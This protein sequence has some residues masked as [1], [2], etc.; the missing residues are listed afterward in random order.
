MAG[1]ELN[2]SPV[3]PKASPVPARPAEDPLTKD[4]WRTLLAIADTIVPS[5][6]AESAGPSKHGLVIDDSAYSLTLSTLQQ[7]L[8]PTDGK[9]DVLAKKFLEERPSENPAFKEILTRFFGLWAP[10]EAKQQITLILNLLN[11]RPGAA[12]LTGYYAPFHT[13]P[14][15]TRQAI[16]QSWST[17]RIPTFRLL[18]KSFGLI[19]KQNWAKTSPTISEVISFPRTPLHGKPAKGFPYEFLQIPP[20]DEPEVIETDVVIVGSGCGGAV[21]ARNL[22]ESGMKVLVVDRGY[23]WAPEHLPMTEAEGMEQLFLNGGA[24]TCKWTFGSADRRCQA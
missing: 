1:P 20:G 17:A 16:L 8:K 5:I 21:V 18:L 13:H 7:R 6:H 4:Q 24:N 23:Y 14:V 3:S 9:V 10:S 22:A 2:A 19:V 11:S 12:L 15:A